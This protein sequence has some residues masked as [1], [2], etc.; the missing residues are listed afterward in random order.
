[1]PL[2]YFIRCVSQPK[3]VD[4]VLALKSEALKTWSSIP[5]FEGIG[6]GKRAGRYE[7]R[8]YVENESVRDA[9][10]DHIGETPVV[11]IVT[12]GIY[13]RPT[14]SR[15]VA[16]NKSSKDMGVDAKDKVVTEFG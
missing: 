5:G 10:P 9:I 14:P 3:G 16:E 8:V 12:G 13:A 1:L 2:A 15:F 7:L 4:T 11:T 6:I